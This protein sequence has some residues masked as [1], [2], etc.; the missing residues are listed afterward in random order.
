M[1]NPLT[2]GICPIVVAPPPP[3]TD[4]WGAAAI[5]GQPWAIIRTSS[6]VNIASRRAATL[7]LRFLAVPQE[8]E[9]ITAYFLPTDCQPFP[10]D[11]ESLEEAVTDVLAADVESGLVLSRE[12]LV[13][14]VGMVQAALGIVS[15]KLQSVSGDSVF[16]WRCFVVRSFNASQQTVP[17]PFVVTNK[18]PASAQSILEASMEPVVGEFQNLTAVRGTNLDIAVSGK[19]KPFVR[20]NAVWVGA[21]ATY[22]CKGGRSN[23][24]GDFA[25]PMV[26]ASGTPSEPGKVEVWVGADGLPTSVDVTLSGS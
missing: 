15:A 11:M 5:N 20:V 19:S 18:K 7:F 4:E 1:P 2:P 22:Q 21:G 6:G 9:T 16:S 12:N 25:F 23:A 3:L 24:N 13:Q 26:K 8:Q 14:D 17:V 10:L